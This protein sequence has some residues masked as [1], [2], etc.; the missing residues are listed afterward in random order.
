MPATG[1][2]RQGYNFRAMVN[3]RGQ[4]AGDRSNSLQNST[5]RADT[6]VMNNLRAQ[7]ANTLRQQNNRHA[8]AGN[9]TR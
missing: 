9:N 4:Q 3:D 6:N 8:G 5:S 2:L 1:Q 7:L